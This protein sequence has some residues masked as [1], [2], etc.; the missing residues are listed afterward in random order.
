M[1]ILSL[2]IGAQGVRDSDQGRTVGRVK[3][4]SVWEEL[5]GLGFAVGKT[6]D[7]K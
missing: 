1:L 2:V 5:R 7:C 4:I 3:A 6:G